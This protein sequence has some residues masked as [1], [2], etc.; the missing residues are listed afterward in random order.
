[1]EKFEIPVKL[2]EDTEK[3]I[4]GFFEQ[5]TEALKTRP[6]EQQTYLDDVEH[7]VLDEGKKVKEHRATHSNLE[8]RIMSL[9]EYRAILEKIKPHL[10]K[11][12]KQYSNVGAENELGHQGSGIHFHYAAGVVNVVKKEQFQRQ[13][14]RASRNNA[15]SF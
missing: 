2:C 14:F 10:P 1:M 8:K 4:E 15:M 7:F 9:F 6:K 3:G 13:V 12:F 5:L 11:N